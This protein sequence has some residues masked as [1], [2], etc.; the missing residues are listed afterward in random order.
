[1]DEISKGFFWIPDFR[2]TF[3]IFC[4]YDAGRIS[5]SFFICRI[6]IW[7][8]C[9]QVQNWTSLREKLIWTNDGRNFKDIFSNF[10]FSTHIHDFRHVI[11]QALRLSLCV[12]KSGPQ[13]Y[14][15]RKFSRKRACGGGRKNIVSYK[16]VI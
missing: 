3:P 13:I 7:F 11:W 2:H 10:R 6:S 12:S 15:A 16:Y 8:F 4:I 1:M 5:I 14:T 9:Q